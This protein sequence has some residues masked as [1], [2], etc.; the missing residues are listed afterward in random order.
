MAVPLPIKFQSKV[1][2]FYGN[3]PVNSNAGSQIF[4]ITTGA[5][6]TVGTL[7]HHQIPR[8]LKE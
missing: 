5:V 3:M 6:L 8:V 7:T 2:K 4:F 1:M